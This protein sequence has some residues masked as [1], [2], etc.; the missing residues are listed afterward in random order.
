MVNYGRP[1]PLGERVE[2]V[3]AAKVRELVERVGGK[4][5]AT[6]GSVGEN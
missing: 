6:T 2:E 1:G 4:T 3:I 5:A